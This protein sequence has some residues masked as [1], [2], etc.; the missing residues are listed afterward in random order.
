M[1]RTRNFAV[2]QMKD[3]GEGR[4]D[5]SPLIDR[6]RGCGGEVTFNEFTAEDQTG[7]RLLMADLQ[8]KGVTTIVVIGF[9][10]AVTAGQLN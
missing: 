3:A 9:E 10:S 7:N 5:V 1:A 4:G 8:Q 6:I 2:L